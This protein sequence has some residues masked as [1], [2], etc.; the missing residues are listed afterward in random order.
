M[1]DIA[2]ATHLPPPGREWTV[3]LPFPPSVNHMWRRVGDKTVLSKAGREYR[4]AAVFEILKDAARNR[5]CITTR[6]EVRIDLYPSTRR[7]F[8]IDNNV[9]AVLDAITHAGLWK[10]DNQVDRLIVQR[11][12]VQRPGH[13]VVRIREIA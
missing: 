4:S 12:D 3:V 7:S 5:V 1:S 2:Y 13:A 10:D 8:D 11:C 9:K 6:V